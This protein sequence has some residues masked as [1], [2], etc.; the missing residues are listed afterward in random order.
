M[1]PYD[2]H[3]HRPS[4]EYQAVSDHQ[5]VPPGLQIRMSVGED[6]GKMAR[7][8]DPWQL[9]LWIGSVQKFVRINVRKDDDMATLRRGIADHIGVKS[10]QVVLKWMAQT[11]ANQC[12]TAC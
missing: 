10:A 2:A 4:Y 12:S 8:P 5:E 9:S 7:I 1:K 3:L 11:I 6:R